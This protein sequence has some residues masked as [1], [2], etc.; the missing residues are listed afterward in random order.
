MIH[1]QM[2]Y[3]QRW[4]RS[5]PPRCRA[6]GFACWLC[7]KKLYDEEESSY[8]GIETNRYSAEARVK[9]MHVGTSIIWITR[10]CSTSGFILNFVPLEKFMLL[11][12][13]AWRARARRAGTVQE[14]QRRKLGYTYGISLLTLAAF[15]NVG[16]ELPT[17]TTEF[18]SYR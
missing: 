17:C 15:V 7:L 3:W 11:V 10:A 5:G 14:Y 18:S 8:R 2:P 9:C 13:P 16:A 12:A 6:A 1:R 4:P